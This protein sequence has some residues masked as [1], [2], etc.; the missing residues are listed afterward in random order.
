MKMY[1][2]YSRLPEL[3][4][5]TRPQRR[6]VLRCALEAFYQ[7]EPSRAWAGLPW[8]T[9]GILGGALVGVILVAIGLSHSKLLVITGC[10][11]AGAFL[12]VFIAGQFSTAQLRPYL[13]RVL[14][15]R[16]NELSQIK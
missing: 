1:F 2:S 9:G 7:D 8:I 11:L 5:L 10:A 16:K 14:E 13:R 15:E 12:G 4:G 6:A 3:A